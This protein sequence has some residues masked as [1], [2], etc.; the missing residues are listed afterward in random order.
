MSVHI[1]HPF[2]FGKDGRT[3]TTS[4]AE[5]IQDLVE[6]TLLT[7]PGERVNRPQF[8]AGL[9]TLIFEPNDQPLSDAAQ[10]LT[11]SNLQRWLEGLVE[12]RSLDVTRKDETLHISLE[13]VVL[14][15][16]ETISQTV[17]RP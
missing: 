9:S 13:Y 15:S 5:H 12:I 10:F 4:R 14:A 6:L 8:G 11:R 16:G 3:A 2:R 7:A 17:R 1:D